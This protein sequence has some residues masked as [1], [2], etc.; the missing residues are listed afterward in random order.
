MNGWQLDIDKWPG[1]NRK[2]WKGLREI[3]QESPDGKYLA[4]L[5]SCGEIDIYKEVG[6]CAPE[7]LPVLLPTIPEEIFNGLRI[8]SAWLVLIVLGPPF[9]HQDSCNS[10]TG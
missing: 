10:F 1:P 2:K 4:V 6:F 5:Y 9:L 8:G 3:F 7:A